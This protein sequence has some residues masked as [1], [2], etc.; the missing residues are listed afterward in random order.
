MEECERAFRGTRIRASTG[1]VGLARLRGGLE[2]VRI[3]EPQRGEMAVWRYGDRFAGRR[4]RESIRA[5][6]GAAVAGAW[7]AG[8]GALCVV[9]FPFLD[10]R[11]VDREQV[12]R[13]MG[14]DPDEILAR[15]EAGGPVPRGLR[16]RRGDLERVRVL[17]P[18]GALPWRLR[19]A[20]LEGTVE[21]AGEDALRAAR[22]LLPAIN[23]RGA[24]RR[25]VRRA[26]ELLD[27]ADGPAD[28]FARAPV[29]DPTQG[30][31]LPVVELDLPVR[32]ALEMAAH[33]EAERRALEGE[34]GALE[35][36]WIEAERIAAIADRLAIP[37]EVERRLR[38]A[39]SR[40][41]G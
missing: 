24:G 18:E 20:A 12:E 6:A 40:G 5:T 37:D 14:R 7:L 17:P 35:R 33:E 39:R 11:E 2:L 36:E 26:V 31:P 28:F 25:Q 32:L 16:V 21:L 8:W 27:G 9:L 10:P 22:L 13:W 15:L 41:T 3:G 34:L 1:N 30:F 19:V 4:V 38:D 29:R 23:R